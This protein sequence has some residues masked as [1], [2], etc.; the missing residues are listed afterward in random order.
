MLRAHRRIEPSSPESVSYANSRWSC[1]GMSSCKCRK[2]ALHSV[3][4]YLSAA[5]A[6]HAR[7][8]S[9]QERTH[10]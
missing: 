10:C 2:H 4:I 7:T 9:A 5:R 8:I 6:R 3:F 1:D